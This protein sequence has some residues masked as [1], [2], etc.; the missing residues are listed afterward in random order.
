MHH[1][2]ALHTQ[3][4]SIQGGGGQSLLNFSHSLIF[5]S[6]EPELPPVSGRGGAN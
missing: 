3:A 1:G 5:Y 4:L 2:F 6:V